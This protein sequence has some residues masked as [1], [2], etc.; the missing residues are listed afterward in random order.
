MTEPT[1]ELP[2]QNAT[3][4][5]KPKDEPKA[6]EWA[7]RMCVKCHSPFYVGPHDLDAAADPVFALCP[8][9]DPGRFPARQ[10]TRTQDGDA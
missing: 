9:C 2:W 3:T 1:R 6:T 4:K 10:A 7:N 8:V 5:A